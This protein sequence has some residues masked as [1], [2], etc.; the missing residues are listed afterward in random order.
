MAGKK[1]KFSVKKFPATVGS[2]TG[3]IYKNYTILLSQ[4]LSKYKVDKYIKP[5]MG[6]ILFL[7]WDSDNLLV[8]DIAK[9]LELP[10]TTVAD[11]VKRMEKTGL[12]KRKKDREDFRAIR[13]SLTPLAWSLRKKTE[14][15]SEEINEVLMSQM[16]ERQIKEGRRFLLG[17][18]SASNLYLQ[19]NI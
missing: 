13:I 10:F 2:F 9:R 7:L 11:A 12:V 15:L 8:K 4:Y 1:S 6:P 19:K 17:L 5:G 16:S 3:R 18:L 14:K